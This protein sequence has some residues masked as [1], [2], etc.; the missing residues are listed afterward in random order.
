MRSPSARLSLG[1]G[2]DH[3]GRGPADLD[4]LYGLLGDVADAPDQV[5]LEPPG[6]LAG[7]GRDQDVVDPVVLDPVLHR[8]ERVRAHRLAGCVDVVA[9]E[10][11]KRR[12]EVT[13]DLSL[14]DVL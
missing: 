8:Q 7:E 5:V 13:G 12:S 10:L 3:G 6:A 14:A 1:D 4:V 9:V 11:G 2:S